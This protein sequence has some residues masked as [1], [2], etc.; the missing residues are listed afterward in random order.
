MKPRTRIEKEVV[1][2][3]RRLGE[4]PTERQK[5]WMLSHSNAEDAGRFHRRKA[6]VMHFIIVTTCHGW[7]VLRHFYCYAYYRRKKLV[8]AGYSVVMEEWL[9]DGQYVFLSRDRYCMGC[10][11][12]AWMH[13]HPLEVRHGKLGG[14]VVQDPREIGYCDVLFVR[15]QDKYR[16]LPED[17]AVREYVGTMYRA[18]N[19]HP[20]NETLLKQN[21]SLF[22]WSKYNGFLY[23]HEKTAAIRIARRYHYGIDDLW[24]DMIESLAYL[25]K[26]LHNPALVCPQDGLDAHDRWC[27]AAGRKRKKMREKMDKLR[28]IRDEHAELR[29]MQMQAEYEERRKEEAKA[30][31]P[32]YAK[33]RGRFFGLCIAENDLEI[34][35]LQSVQEFMEEGKEME[36][37]VFANAY[38]DVKR[39]PNCLI[40]SARV[41]G[42]RCET[43]E[44]DLSKYQVVQCRGRKNA[45]TPYHDTILNLM[46]ANMNQIKQLNTARL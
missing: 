16:Y 8:E 20:Y 43:I 21:K 5:K 1:L 44:V 26:D 11:N 31:I 3:S 42:K 12:D 30:A 40:L 18:V 19:A 32:L 17:I 7:Q 41:G 24:K 46:N 14:S 37:C 25:G 4:V 34:K 39:K 2:L 35:V 22:D 28:Q 27:A 6:D 13:G 15:V 36:H 9:K 10:A 45:N 33:A 38:Y 29:R 23:D